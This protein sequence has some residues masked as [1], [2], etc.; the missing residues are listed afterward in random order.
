[1]T[2]MAGHLIVML[3]AALILAG[4]AVSSTSAGV[5]VTMRRQLSGAPREDDADPLHVMGLL[6]WMMF[7]GWVAASWAV[8]GAAGAAMLTGIGILLPTAPSVIHVARNL[9][10]RIG[11][12]A[13]GRASLA[14]EAVVTMAAVT[15][16]LAG[17]G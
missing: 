9:V 6:H 15:V 12:G 5:L 1:M 8:F 2:G 10:G 11:L 7:A 13:V 16:Y 3:F 14:A 4:I 17:F